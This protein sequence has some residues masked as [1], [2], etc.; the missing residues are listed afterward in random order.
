MTASGDII[1]KG[2]CIVNLLV[3]RLKYG[4]LFWLGSLGVRRSISRESYG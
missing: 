2:L 4:G 3:R 1:H